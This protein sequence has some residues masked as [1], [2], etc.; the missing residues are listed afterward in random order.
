[1]KVVITTATLDPERGRT[2]LALA[3]ATAG[4]D[5]KTI[6]AV[7]TKQHGGVKTANHAWREALKFDPDYL[8]Y[9][10]DDVKAKQEGWAL[11]LIRALRIRADYGIAAPGGRCV[12]NPQNKAKPGMAR[13]VFVVSSLSFL[14][15]AIKRAVLDK[16]GVFDERY[17]HFGCDSDYCKRA[18]AAGWKCI[19]VR[20][21]YLVH[22]YVPTKQRPAHV[23]RWK[24]HD[25]S[26]FYKL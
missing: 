10:N 6:M 2:T 1:V 13:G 20:H 14:A 15:V 11:E 8:I 26:E 7:D 24:N 19:W 4:L 9:I 18:Q 3:E 16:L 22:N 12:T 23:Q 17:I 25:M 21:V 5:C